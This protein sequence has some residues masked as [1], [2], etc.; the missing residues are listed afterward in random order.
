MPD[1]SI[2][3][4][5]DYWKRD[6]SMPG[7]IV[8]I[9][10]GDD[11]RS[12]MRFAA[13]EPEAAC[14]FLV[15]RTEWLR[16]L[17][18]ERQIALYVLVRKVDTVAAKTLR[19][20]L[21]SG[22]ADF[23]AAHDPEAP[24]HCEQLVL[25]FMKDGT[26]EPGFLEKLSAY[27][28]IVHRRMQKKAWLSAIA[29]AV[30]MTVGAGALF[31]CC[32]GSVGN[33]SLWIA[34]TGAVLAF[35]TWR[36][37]CLNAFRLVYA[38]P[39]WLSMLLSIGCFSL[40]GLHLVTA[41]LWIPVLLIQLAVWAVVLLAARKRQG[42]FTGAVRGVVAALFLVLAL[43]PL[44][45]FSH[46]PAPRLIKF[47]NSGANDREMSRTCK[48]R[49]FETLRRKY[50][51]MWRSSMDYRKW[52]NALGDAAALAVRKSREAA[53]APRSERSGDVGKKTSA[54]WKEFDRREKAFSELDPAGASFVDHTYTK[55][56][57]HHLF[58]AGEMFAAMLASEHNLA[59]Y[60][61]LVRTA[62]TH[63]EA[64]DFAA[65]KESTLERITRRI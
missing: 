56:Y 40:A 62:R 17:G 51:A 21:L 61:D 44:Y 38:P 31:K 60:L 23:F 55:A 34:L 45:Y 64:G 30:L 46:W 35:L 57:L 26:F 1:N 59:F 24:G 37:A 19:K 25:R 7:K 6:G 14:E 52:Q 4:L 16:G 47:G 27:G 9:D 63:I 58:A 28:R 39:I 43:W 8:R 33:V 49:K 42:F 15:E 10:L 5:K 13:G 12:W 11:F 20:L 65:W 53:A 50:V 48:Q 41:K 36:T 2:E 29:T 32:G 22:I 18:H 3:F 54:F